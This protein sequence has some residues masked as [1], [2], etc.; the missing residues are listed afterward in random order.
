MFTLIFIFIR[1][2]QIYKSDLSHQQKDMRKGFE[3][4]KDHHRHGCIKYQITKGF[5]NIG[6]SLKGGK[7]HNILK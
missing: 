5:Y 2:H 6:K 4:R 3:L 7:Y 1:F